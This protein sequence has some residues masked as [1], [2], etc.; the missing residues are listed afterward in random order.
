[1]YEFPS[2]LLSTFQKPCSLDQRHT[3]HELFEARRSGGHGLNLL[4]LGGLENVDQ[5]RQHVLDFL[6]AL[7]SLRTQTAL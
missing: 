4:R 7:D 5:S 6:I 2:A 1:M 3:L